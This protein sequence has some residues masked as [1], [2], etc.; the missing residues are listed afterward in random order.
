MGE[1]MR[2]LKVLTPMLLALALVGGLLPN[3]GASSTHDGYIYMY[4]N[5]AADAPNATT[6]WRFYVAMPGYVGLDD[7][8][9]YW[10]FTAYGQMVN[11]SGEAYADNWRLTI[12]IEATGVNQSVTSDITCSKTALVYGNLS[13][14]ETIYSLFEANS[15]ADVYVT[16]TNITAATV[17]DTWS[18]TI[19]IESNSMIG[20]TYALVGVVVSIAILVMVIGW[21]GGITEEMQKSMSPRSSGSRKKKSKR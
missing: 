9:E 16:L 2:I 19:R 1:C 11:N 8:D 13:F 18:G 17:V 15:S 3:T 4:D 21:F 20:M 6:D 7:T 14:T 5:G 12:Y 10:N